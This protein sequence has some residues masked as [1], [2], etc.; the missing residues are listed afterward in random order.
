MGNR[1]IYSWMSLDD[2]RNPEDSRRSKEHIISWSIGGSDGLVTSDVST[3]WNND[4]G[5]SVD[6]PFADLL[7]L[8]IKRHQLGLAGKSGTIPPIRW[9]VESVPDSLPATMIITSE[10]DV[11]FDFKPDIKLEERIGYQ[12]Y[13]VAGSREKVRE[14]LDGILRK[15]RSRKQ[16]TYSMAGDVITDADEY[17]KSAQADQVDLFH[18]KILCFDQEIW[19]RGLF[20]IILGLAHQVLG[21]T[22][23]F[24]TYGDRVRAIVTQPRDKWPRFSGG[25]G[26]LPKDISTILGIDESTRAANMH[27]LAILPRG[28]EGALG[29]DAVIS[30]FGGD[31]PES[32]VSIGSELGKLVVVNDML[33]PDAVVGFRV[34]PRTRKTTSIS[35]RTIVENTP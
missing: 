6:A 10:G 17:T 21:E 26:T 14:I 15:S 11:T 31:V 33:R 1:C 24:G 22:W 25:T 29:A 28:K 8:A 34:D 27:T 3:K 7:P 30:L 4:L 32:L 16:V 12:Q 20:K 9:R 2:V 23:T 13:F 19:M 35:A 18:G 5:T